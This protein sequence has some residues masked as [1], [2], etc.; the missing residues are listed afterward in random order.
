[1][2]TESLP[3]QGIISFKNQ[4]IGDNSVIDSE[5]SQSIP[6]Y[7]S[8]NLLTAQRSERWRSSDVNVE[9]TLDFTLNE[10]I[11]PKLLAFIDS[12]LPN[13][14]TYAV[15][16]P[17]AASG[18]LLR[19]L[20]E[21]IIAQETIGDGGRYHGRWSPTDDTASTRAFGYEGK[22]R[23]QE[24]YI[25][26]YESDGTTVRDGIYN[27]G[28]VCTSGEACDQW[29]RDSAS[30]SNQDNFD[31]T[32]GS[33]QPTATSGAI[34]ANNNFALHFDGGDVMGRKGG[35]ASSINDSVL[36]FYAAIRFDNTTGTHGIMGSSQ[37]T[38]V[39]YNGTNVSLTDDSGSHTWNLAWSANANQWYVFTLLRVQGE[40]ALYIDGSQEG[41]TVDL[42]A[43]TSATT[44]IEFIG[45]DDAT[46][47]NGLTG[48][49]GAFG[50]DDSVNSVDDESA[51]Q[52]I[53]RQE[54]YL[55]GYIDSTTWQHAPILNTSGVNGEATIEFDGTNSYQMLVAESRILQQA[56]FCLT[57]VVKF[58]TLVGNN[59]IFSGIT[60]CLRATS[61]AW[62]AIINNETVSVS[63]TVSTGTW[64]VVT[65]KRD[66]RTVEI[67]VNG[68]YIGG[69][70]IQSTAYSDLV[71]YLTHRQAGNMH[72]DGEIA[73]I[74][75]HNRALPLAEVVDMH[76]ALGT[77]Y[78]IT[79]PDRQMKLQRLDSAS[80]SVLQTW[81]FDFKDEA[82]SGILKY[83][84][85]NDDSGSAGTAGQYWRV[86]L[87]ASAVRQNTTTLKSDAFHQIG[88]IWLGECRETDIS[89]NLKQR[90]IDKSAVSISM[91]GASCVDQN[92]TYTDLRIDL[93]YNTITD[94]QAIKEE[95]EVLG[96]DGLAIVDIFAARGADT[97]NLD[98]SGILYGRLMSLGEKPKGGTLGHPGQTWGKIR[99]TFTEA[100]R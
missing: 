10:S 33:K 82:E 34:S 89:H 92:E 91:N 100:A 47:S 51:I 5:T 85:G 43:A 42:T 97:D 29:Q 9:Q 58:D 98:K 77:R 17:L 71:G 22:L 41:T 99:L 67:W 83:Y 64:Y 55:A 65:L 70:E 72:F 60:N 13:G 68:E 87:P 81:T 84:L 63:D 57:A 45:G 66:G 27:S 28:D 32:S 18:D 30:A 7:K 56:N 26:E 4:L 78:D 94:W 38:T 48:Y 8:S 35:V 40:A 54:S 21:D 14:T 52:G 23:A 44:S 61:T 37:G 12:N 74:I 62:E 96:V 36:E 80:G 86:V 20:P 88:V 6:Y 76:S 3:N 50:F 39:I 90:I 46:P 31:Q 16:D 24:D 59:F 2:A 53:I 93:P 73:D 25:I 49:I 11:V 75:V 69:G 95:L 79:M 1:M 15:N 19:Y